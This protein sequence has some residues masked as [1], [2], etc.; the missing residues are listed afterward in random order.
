MTMLYR[1]LGVRRRETGPVFARCYE[2]GTSCEDEV[3]IHIVQSTAWKLANRT[4]TMLTPLH[5]SLNLK[6][7]VSSCPTE[8]ACA[9]RHESRR[10]NSH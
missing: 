6:V 8:S 9:G 3:C 4:P 7:Y 1:L 10:G 2:T 5:E